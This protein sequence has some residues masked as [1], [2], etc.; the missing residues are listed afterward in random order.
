ME[1][2]QLY[3]RSQLLLTVFLVALL[4]SLYARLHKQVFFCWWA[5][6]WTSFA[7]FLALGAVALKLAPEWTL[8][9]SSIVLAA[10][11]CG[12]L[13]V[14][15][16]VFGAWTLRPSGLPARYWLRIGIGLALAASLLSFALAYY[17]REES[18]T[19]FAIRTAPRTLALSAALFF[20]AWVLLG[21]WRRTRSWAAGITGWFCL[22]YALDQGLYTVLFSNRLLLD[23]GVS[24]PQFFGLPVVLSSPLFFLDLLCSC[25]ICFGTVVVLVEEHQR[26]EHALRECTDRNQAIVAA[27][28]ALLTQ[29]RER[30]RA[31]AELRESEDRYR[32]LVEHSQDLICIHDLQGRF[33]SANPAAARILGY[34]AAELLGTSISERV[35]P[36]DRDQ[37]DEYLAKLRKDG[38][39]DGIGTVTTRTGEKRIWEYHCTVRTEGV[40]FP[41]VRSM[42]RDV[43]ERQRAEAALRESEDRYRDLVEHSQDL[44]CTHDLEGRLLSVNPA[45]ARI[46]GYEVSEL[47]RIPLRDLLAPEFRDRFE[48][49]LARIRKDAVADGLMTIMTRTGK[50]RVWEYHNTL[51]TEGVPFPIVRSMAHDVTERQRAEAKLRESEDRYRD[52]VEHSQDWIVTHDLEGHMLSANPATA[53]MLGREVEEL[54][55]TPMRD[56]VPPEFRDKFDEYLAKLRK[57]GTAEGTG[58]ITTR[59]GEQKIFEYHSTVRTEGVPFPIVRDICHDVTERWRAEEALKKSEEKFSR[60][61]R[62]SPMPLALSSTKDHRYI[63]VNE[64]FERITGWRRDE[65]IGHTPYDIGLYVDPAQRLELVNRV[66]TEGSFRNQEIC[67]RMRDGSVRDVLVSAELMELDGEPCVLNV[68]ADI[69]EYKQVQEA[70]KKSEEKFSKAFRQSPMSLVLTSVKDHRY[71]DVNE[72]FERITG[73]R[74]DE[75]IGRTPFDIELYVDPAQRL[76]LVNRALTEGGFRNQEVRFRTR[77]GSI[78]V[79]LMSAEL[80]ELDGE[81][82]GLSVGA[83]ITE[84]KQV[85]E[86]LK[87]SEEKFSKAFRESPLALSLASANDHRFME[88]NETFERISGWRRDEVIGRTPIDIGLW[89]NPAEMLELTN[90]L[91]TEGSLR[92]LEL[93]FCMRDGSIHIGLVSLEVIELDGEPCVLAVTADITEQKHAQEALHESEDKL[94]LLLDSTAEAIFGIDLEG[95]CTFCNPACLR[96]LGYERVDELLGNDMHDLIHHTRADG[97]LLPVEECRIRRALRA[98]EGT[99]VEDEV[100][101]RVNGTSFPAEYRSYPQ[102]RGQAVVGAVVTF[103]DITERKQAVEALRR[104]EEQ[105]R[106]GQKMEAVGRLAG[107]VAHDFNNLLCGITL[108][109]ELA[110]EELKPKDR[111]LREDL[112]RALE[113]ARSAASVVRQLLTISRRQV[114]QRQLVS[115][116]DVVVGVSDLVSRLLSENIYVSM[117]LGQ[118][119][120]NAKV[121]PQQMQQVVMNL[122]LNAR[123]AMPE[124]GKI[125]VRTDN[126]DLDATPAGEYFTSPPEPGPYVVLEVSDTGYGMSEKTLSHL[127]EPFFTTKELGRGTGLG[128]AIAYGIVTQS[129]GY[130]S[131]QTALG[132]G[133]TFKVYLPRVGDGLTEK[134]P[135]EV[136]PVR[137]KLRLSKPP[138]VL[139]VDDTEVVRDAISRDLRQHGFSVLTASNATEALRI[140]DQHQGVIDLLLT[141]VALPGMNGLELARHFLR[142]R[143]ASKVLYISGHDRD[144]VAPNGAGLNSA[145]L[146]YKPFGSRE[147]LAAID[148]VLSK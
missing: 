146:L 126:V 39:A 111:V 129:G 80:I 19:S 51:R 42:A 74:R 65:I 3:V 134:S 112:N 97:T 85:Q 82:C 77:D 128:L 47:L 92:N 130:I 101:W 2:V 117:R 35:P 16:L 132:H 75:V 95:R 136:A 22:L 26:T 56:N 89:V 11:V 116:N 57:D 118:E 107:G 93:R 78:R 46:L 145:V 84:Y 27:S 1:V 115:L 102:R 86:A 15:L 66:L 37:Y 18:L 45:P 55:R 123:D 81:P 109:L 83:D 38:A 6:A 12:F 29:I 79:V 113:A 59:T 14:P 25:G 144:T 20:C 72:T 73:W 34:E 41:T 61:F 62:Q 110:L 103:M 60:A 49:Y 67:F 7:G 120:G 87:K 64:T 24:V 90:R 91:L 63:D 31:E 48:E 127:F 141:D 143:T 133:T 100:L 23:W 36:E 30:Q 88:V 105:L 135:P 28:A 58:F 71:I 139:L 148:K 10:A 121:D 50:K 131:V 108:H 17:W 142:K 119:L 94:R 13:Q 21:R 33:L 76:E 5:W 137:Q 68:G 147:L 99:H 114:V 40:P 32:D 125:L 98:G 140:G 124:G 70:L 104:S 138:T 9:K 43:T 44:I 53:R 54:L 96:A 4:W 106:H 122:V 69:T 8:L 52:L